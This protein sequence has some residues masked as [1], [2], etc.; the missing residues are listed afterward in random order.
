MDMSNYRGRGYYKIASNDQRLS[1]KKAAN[2][3]ECRVSKQKG[4]IWYFPKTGINDKILKDLKL[5]KVFLGCA[6]NNDDGSGRIGS[7]TKTNGIHNQVCC[8]GIMGWV[9][10]TTEE[11]DMFCSF[12]N[13][14][15]FRFCVSLKKYSQNTSRSTFAA[16]PDIDLS[17]LETVDD[18]SIYKYLNLTEQD[19]KTIE[20]RC[21]RHQLLRTVKEEEIEC[22]PA[23]PKSKKKSKRSPSTAK[24]KR[25]ITEKSLPHSN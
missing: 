21:N 7:P 3:I 8:D 16:V 15:F 12:I 19:I 22:P 4:E 5:P 11:R 1:E 17:L 23:S 6:H 24:T 2:T 9:F 20:E 14:K 25:T 13:T 10:A 18:A